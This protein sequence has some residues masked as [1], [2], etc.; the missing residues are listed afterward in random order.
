MTEHSLAACLAYGFNR[1][2]PG[3]VW[4]SFAFGMRFGPL[5][6]AATLGVFYPHDDGVL[7]AFNRATGGRRFTLARGMNRLLLS[8]GPND[9]TFDFQVAPRRSLAEDVRELGLMLQSVE[10]FTEPGT[11]NDADAGAPDDFVPANLAAAQGAVAARLAR[12]VLQGFLGPGMF[13]PM[14]ATHA[15]KKRLHVTLY[16]PP[17]EA[18]RARIDAPVSINGVIHPIPVELIADGGKPA[19]RG[20]F[21]LASFVGADGLLGDLDIFLADERGREKFPWQSAHWRGPGFGPVPAAEHI[22]R[23]AGPAGPEF[24]LFGGATWCVKLMALFHRLTGRDMTS[25]GPILDWGVG[26][27]RI[28]RF[29]P[30]AIRA[31]LTGVDIDDVNIDWCHANMEGLDARLIAPA[32][33]LPF[34]PE[35]FE[36]VFGHSVMTHLSEADQ[37][38]WLAELARVT[39]PGGICLLTVL[40]ELSWFMRFFP[41]ERTPENIAEFLET[42]FLDDGSVNVGV[43][44]AQP[45]VYR[46]TSHN[47]AYITRT[48]SKYFEIQDI[49]HAFA[50]MQSLVVMRRRE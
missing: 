2:E 23:V 45:G 49:I 33:P 5:T 1:P 42:G 29:L 44:A 47:T 32:P 41:A 16:L 50:D 11:M 12:Q 21:E 10:E 25:C 19:Y 43:D 28:A 27:G 6:Q 37:H 15:G 31:N 3:F 4:S 13:K 24:F 36:L 8:C 7:L 48:W 26:C 30:D 46:N 35:R 17:D 39:K 40:N 9:R 14:I 34:A 20:A 18:L 22:V 38:A